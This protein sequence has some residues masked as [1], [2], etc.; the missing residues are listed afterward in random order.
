MR[1]VGCC[2]RY[3]KD[4][5]LPLTSIHHHYTGNELLA[6]TIFG[7]ERKIKEKK[8]CARE[9]ETTEAGGRREEGIL[10]LHP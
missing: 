1:R 3:I 7:E 5:T 9:R 8:T 2:T 4:Y 10:V 6:N